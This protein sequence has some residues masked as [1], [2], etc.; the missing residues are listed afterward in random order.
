[1][2]GEPGCR[3]QTPPGP[4]P[5]L[6]TEPRATQRGPRHTGYVLTPTEGGAAEGGTVGVGGPVQNVSLSR[7]LGRRRQAGAE[8]G[9]WRRPR[10]QTAGDGGPPP[11]TL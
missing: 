2:G 6:S 7:H 5:P 8:G 4:E 10:A 9:V 11:P 1:M 3:E